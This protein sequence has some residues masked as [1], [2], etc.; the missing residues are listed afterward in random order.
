[1][2]TPHLKFEKTVSLTFSTASMLPEIIH[3]L[4]VIMW[5]IKE[6]LLKT[7]VLFYFDDLPLT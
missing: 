5:K 3:K 6:T 4:L 1:M 2:A 7:T